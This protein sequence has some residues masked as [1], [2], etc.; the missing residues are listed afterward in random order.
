MKNQQ[1]I[2][3]I[4]LGILSSIVLFLHA[5]SSPVDICNHHSVDIPAPPGN[6]VNSITNIT[7]CNNQLPYLWNSI[8]C[9]TAGT[10]NATLTGSNGLDSLATLNLAVIDIA[11]SITNAI[12]CN[13]QLPY[14]WNGNSF[15]SNGTYSVTLTSS[16]GCDSVPIL[17]LTVNSVVTSTSNRTV[18]SNQ[19]PYSW[20]GNN[21]AGAGSYTVT[22]TSAAGCDS[23]ATLIL[24]VSS[25]TSSITN[26]TVCSN[27][28]PYL[29]N[30]NSYPASG[31]YSITLSNSNGCDSVAT[32]VLNSTPVT[33]S[34][35]NVGVCSNQLPYSWNGN[36]YAGAGNFSVVL[37]GSNGC[38]SVATL[39]LTVRPVLAS[40][41]SLTICTGQLPYNWNGNNYAVAGTYSVTLTSIDGCDSIATLRLTSVVFLTSSTN[42]VICNSALPYNWNGNNYL[43]SGIYTA[44]F[45]TPDGCDSIASLDLTILFP[46][47]GTD[48]ITICTEALPFNWHGQIFSTGGTYPI[49]PSVVINPCYSVDTLVLIVQLILPSTSVV[50]VCNNQLPYSWNGN[51][52]STSGLY[53]ITLASSAGCD[54]LA[55]LDLTV[56]T[57][58]ATT[59]SI[60]I[61][62]NQVPYNWNGNNFSTSGLYP[63]ILTGANGCDSI[64]SLNLTVNPVTSSITDLTVCSTQLPFT[65]NGN[66]YSIN[67]TYIVTLTNSSGCDSIATLNFIVQAFLTSTTAISVCSNQLPYTWNGNAYPIAGI[68]PVTL[69]S[70]GGCDSVATLN[71]VVNNVITS[72][73]NVNTCNNQLPY[74]W[75]GNTYT[76]S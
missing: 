38:D 33:T 52:Y 9:L 56:A 41:T 63:V 8:T 51:N 7:I 76:D 21:Y 72:T 6:A 57:I 22:L 30:G 75:N 27:R 15:I 2:L 35:T 12:V 1:Y 48:S 70:S 64:A 59:T 66:N 25:V 14:Q 49:S 36:N 34:S 13:N 54:S 71:L 17:S 45:V 39:R 46:Q 16:S 10:Y 32:L 73:T 5:S 61:C 58:S 42:A 26:R 74:T 65:W 4:V 18:C 24:T 40:T 44:S 3:S 68:Y 43:I 11:I 37:T 47:V 20:N 60:S 69:S 53:G 50:T 67:G 55:N 31:T 23:I 29:W 28:F 62:S 19:L